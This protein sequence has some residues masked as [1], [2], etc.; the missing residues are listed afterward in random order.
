MVKTKLNRTASLPFISFAPQRWA[1][2]PLA[3]IGCCLWL[4]VNPA[5]AQL[6]AL[7]NPQPLTLPGD[8]ASQMIDGVDSFL[9]KKTSESIAR[10]SGY[11]QYDFSSVENYRRS[12]QPNR[13]R[14]A[15]ILGVVERRVANVA[16]ERGLQLA[17]AEQR[18]RITAVRW[19]VVEDP[20][21]GRTIASVYADGLLIEP[22]GEKPT[23]GD[24]IVIP[25]CHE[26]LQSFCGLEKDGDPRNALPLRLAQD[27]FRVLVPLLISRH[28][29]ARNGRSVLTNREF[30]YRSAFILGR[31]VIGY[32]VQKVQAAVDWLQ[33]TRPKQSTGQP[34]V[35]ARPL[36]VVGVGEGGRIALLS[37]ALDERI[38]G[39]CLCG[40]FG[41][42]EQL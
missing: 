17:E 16:L 35:I 34:Q 25:D 7:N 21:P 6:P 27:N 3:I 1:K 28:E 41:P 12:M 32:E 15:N 13:D 22:L 37:A 4:A 19:P 11:W 9:L 24:V 14:L 8:I 36:G 30:V 20:D 31:H 42:L 18:F 5:A 23:V 2:T 26:S 10:R 29:Q 39:L 33:A 38:D 40:S